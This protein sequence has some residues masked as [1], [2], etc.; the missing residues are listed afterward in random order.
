MIPISD[1]LPSSSTIVLLNLVRTQQ[2][3]SKMLRAQ[4]KLTSG[5]LQSALIAGD[6]DAA[7][8]D[9]TTANFVDPAGLV[10]VAA[11]SDRAM[12]NGQ[13]VTIDKPE[14]KN[15]QNYCSRM[16]L[17]HH[18]DGLLIGHDLPSVNETPHP[19]ELL[20]LTPF[21]SQFDGEKLAALV[22]EKASLRSGPEVPTLIHEA[23]CELASNVEAHA[24]VARGFAAA[25]TYSFD[26]GET[27]V[28]AIADGGIGVLE[29][30]REHYDP[31]NAVEALEVAVRYGT[32]GTGEKGRG[33]GLHDVM[34][35]VADLKGQFTV[36]SGNAKLVVKN[37]DY[38]KAV[39]M[40]CVYPGTLIEGKLSCHP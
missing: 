40:P 15:V 1:L 9:L 5:T 31:Q 12:R 17:S 14:D 24:Q 26:T 36:M 34:V 3:V 11:L 35:A 38:I 23:I 13:Q 30:L 22:Y 7:H 37:K 4:S 10:A 25:Q 19:T 21:S 6:P 20:E 28:F 18:L 27:I 16:R 29:S 2:G 33:S 32:S 8:I 39:E